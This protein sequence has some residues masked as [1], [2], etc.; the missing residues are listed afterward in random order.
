M[1]SNRQLY[2]FAAHSNITHT[3]TIPGQRASCSRLL[4]PSVPHGLTAEVAQSQDLSQRK[5]SQVIRERG[6]GPVHKQCEAVQGPQGRSKPGFLPGWDGGQA[7]RRRKGDTSIVYNR[8]E[9]PARRD[10]EAEAWKDIMTFL[11][12]HVF[13][14]NWSLRNISINTFHEEKVKT[15]PN[16]PMKHT[17]NVSIW[18]THIS[19]GKDM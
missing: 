2:L 12:P 9:I 16:L 6:G 14:S 13:T 18:T 3:H 10:R 19:R 11:L 4:A 8:I 1:T 15:L 7:E 17:Q 5:T